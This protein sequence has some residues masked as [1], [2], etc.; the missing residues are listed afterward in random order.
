MP[1]SVPIVGAVRGRGALSN[2]SGRFETD[3]REDFDDGWTDRDAP[4]PRLDDTLTPLKS[5]TIISRNDSPDIGFDRSINPYV[6]CSHGC[7]Y[8]FARP[9]HAYMGLSPGLDFET[10]L[11]FKP[12]AAKLLEQ[13]LSRPG[14]RPAF[15]QLGASREGGRSG[16]REIGREGGQDMLAPK[17]MGIK[18]SVTVI[19]VI[20]QRRPWTGR[21]PLW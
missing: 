11:F 3:Q 6:G 15:I 10:R 9:S 21:T 5:R 17:S 2:R 20:R 12:D 13:E 14:Y 19:R 16:E 8:C 1:A 18:W 7:I 4:P